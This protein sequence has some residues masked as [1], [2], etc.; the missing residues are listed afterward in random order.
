[1]ELIF[2]NSTMGKSESAMTTDGIKITLVHRTKSNVIVYY[3][4]KLIAEC[5]NKQEALETVS[6]H[7]TVVELDSSESDQSIN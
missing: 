3:G 7:T 4:D 1:M 5:K 6:A 2:T